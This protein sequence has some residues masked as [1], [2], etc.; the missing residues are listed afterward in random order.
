MQLK[1][2]ACQLPKKFKKMLWVIWTAGENKFLKNWDTSFQEKISWTSWFTNNSLMMVKE[3]WEELSYPM[4]SVTTKRKLLMIEALLKLYKRTLL[5]DVM[6][7][8]HET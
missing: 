7:L 6:F 8:M 3:K 5:T 4:S 2:F 1:K